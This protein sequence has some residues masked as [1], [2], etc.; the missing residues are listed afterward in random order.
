MELAAASPLAVPG[1]RGLEFGLNQHQ[2]SRSTV[3]ILSN[4]RS[5]RAPG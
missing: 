3:V 4:G 5:H 2:M 1:G